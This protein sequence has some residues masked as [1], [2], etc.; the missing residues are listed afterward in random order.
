MKSLTR[1]KY[2]DK[3][4]ISNGFY[5]TLKGVIVDIKKNEK[6]KGYKVDINGE[7][8]I[9]TQLFDDDLIY[10]EKERC[11]KSDT[12]KIIGAF[13]FGFWVCFIIGINIWMWCM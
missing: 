3:V 13:I 9:I 11:F 4:V 1:F 6:E 8:L 5:R 7:P 2:K 10:Y 12:S